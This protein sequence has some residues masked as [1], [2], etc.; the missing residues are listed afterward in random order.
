MYSAM[1]AEEE[2]I[3]TE[4]EAQGVITEEELEMQFELAAIE[5]LELTIT[6]AVMTFFVVAAIAIAFYFITKLLFKKFTH[7]YNIYNVTE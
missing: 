5:G 7:N 1:E 4:E 3:I 2:L 6:A